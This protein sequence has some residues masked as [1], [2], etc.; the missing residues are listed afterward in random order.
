M[1]MVAAGV[2]NIAWDIK[3]GSVSEELGEEL[4]P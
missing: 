4:V 2:V 3:L 1:L